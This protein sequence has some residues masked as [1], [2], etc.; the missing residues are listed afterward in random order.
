MSD[1]LKW[2]ILEIVQRNR[3]CGLSNYSEVDQIF[4]EYQV[5][6]CVAMTQQTCLCISQSG[7]KSWCFWW[8]SWS[9]SNQE[10]LQATVADLIPNDWISK[11]GEIPYPKVPTIFNHTTNDLKDFIVVNDELYLQGSCGVLA[12][13]LSLIEAN[14]ELCHIHY[15]S[16]EENGISFYRRL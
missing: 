11:I 14:E 3:F 13:S 1:D 5:R 8:G 16:F 7:F 10:T 15:L 2:A 6:A 12:C 4:L 9:E